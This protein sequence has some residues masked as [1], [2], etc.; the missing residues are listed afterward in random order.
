MEDTAFV[1]LTK[2]NR[3]SFYDEGAETRGRKCRR[4]WT[5][6]GLPVLIG[7]PRTLRLEI[8]LDRCHVTC[9]SVLISL[10][11]LQLA[12]AGFLQS[13]NPHILV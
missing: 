7:R 12:I 6:A 11:V 3:H 5:W 4:I 9:N 1:D 8:H 2:G 10:H 13:R